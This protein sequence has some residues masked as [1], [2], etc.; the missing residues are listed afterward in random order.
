MIRVNVNSQIYIEDFYSSEIYLLDIN[1]MKLDK[2]EQAHAVDSIG[3]IA[4][5][6]CGLFKKKKKIF[7]LFC[8]EAKPYLLID[9]RIIDIKEERLKIV[10]HSFFPFIQKL[11]I[12]QNDK[13]FYC[14]RWSKDIDEF[15]MDDFFYFLEFSFKQGFNNL[16]LNKSTE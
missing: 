16:C 11:T 2:A 3:Y 1:T 7:A 8:Y 9:N 14:K 4:F 15:S 10:F 12:Y 6:S 5:E 13:K